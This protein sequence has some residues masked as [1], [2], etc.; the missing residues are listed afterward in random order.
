MGLDFWAGKRVLI[1][2]HTGFKGGWLSLWLQALGADVTGYA[3]TPPTSPSLFEIA[4]VDNGMCGY[5]GDVRDFDTFAGVV[6]RVQ[7]QIVI[8]MAAQSLVRYSYDNPIETYAVNVLG[9]VHLFEAVRRA[10]GVRVVL[11]VTSDKCYENRE[12]LCGYRESDL[13]GGRDPYSASKACAELVTSAYQRTYFAHSPGLTQRGV[14]VA[15]VRAGNVIGGGD[16]AN[17]RLVPDIMRAIMAHYPVVI[18]SPNAIRPWQHVL[19]ALSGYLMLI[20]KMWTDGP[21]FSEGWNFGPAEG[22]EWSVLQIVEY[23]T[24][25]WGGGASWQ[26]TDESPL[27]EAGCLKLN[28]EKARTRLGWAPKWD[29]GAALYRTIEWFRAYQHREDMREMTLKQIIAYVDCVNG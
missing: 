15:S 23:M 6:Q 3:L 13:L 29:I 25:W 21:A 14:A 8:H 2:G 18:R 5:V 7:P 16:W 1:T 28:S 20:E 24:S 4:R 19:D 17:D 27:R 10:G 22:H 12:L 9:T 26:L 11:N